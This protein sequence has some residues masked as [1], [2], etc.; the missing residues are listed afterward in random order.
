MTMEGK[1]I[2]AR[3]R[4]D[5]PDQYKWNLKD[6]FG[7]S[8]EWKSAKERLIARIADLTHFKENLGASSAQLLNGLDCYFDLE[9]EF[10]R[11]SDYASMLSDQDT[12]RQEELAMKQEMVQL[13]TLLMGAASFMEPEILRMSKEMIDEFLGEN[14]GL[15][16]YRQYLDDV[17][18]RREHTLD[19]TEEKLL[20]EAGLMADT[21][22]EAHGVL[23]NAD[24]PYGTIRLSDGREVR[25]DPTSYTLHRASDDRDERIKTFNTFFGALKGFERTLGTE[26]YG[27]IKKNLFYRNARRYSSCLESALFR[28]NIPLGVYRN[29]IENI[30]ANLP[31]LHRYLGLRKRLLGLDELHYYDLYPSMVREVGLTFDYGQAKEAILS[32]LSR[33]GEEY[34]GLVKK[35][36]GEHWM[37]IYP[38]AGKRSGA[39]MS[40]Q[41]YDVHP[42]I[43]ANFNGKYDDVSTLAHELGHAVHS[44]FSNRYQPYVNSRYPIFLAEVASTVNEAL[45]MDFQLKRVSEKAEKIS[46]LGGYLEGFRTTLFRQTQFAEFELRI[47]EAAENGEALTGDKFTKIYLD[48]LKRYYGHGEGVCIIDDFYGIEWAYI[49]HFFMNFYVFQY[50]T[51][52]TA[53]QAVAAKIING[54]GGVVDRYMEFLKSGSSDYAIPTLRKLGIDMLSREPFDLAIK[55]MNEIIDMIEDLTS[56]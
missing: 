22:G 27:E 39:Y 47:H 9:K 50:S 55:R 40:G 19:E 36:F 11:I 17:T 20:A 32:A 12:R 26:L 3:E 24:L 56:G 21:P 5:I 35:A 25:I 14:P 29:L 18:R 37:D 51:S 52:F 53:S 45:L 6:L 2:Q 15:G 48:I 34:A 13:R 23:T 33:L 10:M 42:Y 7:S 43:L 38:N 46:L 44:S 1:V 28:D 4:E 8:V 54:E 49:P 30:N 16:I 31:A 41:A